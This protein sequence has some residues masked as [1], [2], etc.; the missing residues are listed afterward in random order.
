MIM[1]TSRLA[2]QILASVSGPDEVS[3]LPQRIGVPVAG[4]EKFSQ[5]VS[6][7]QSNQTLPALRLA[8]HEYTYR[9]V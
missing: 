5:K 6:R 4:L 9:I 3:N 8:V 1:F 7:F 2:V